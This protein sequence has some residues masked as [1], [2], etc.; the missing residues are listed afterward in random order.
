MKGMEKMPQLTSLVP[1]FL[2]D[3]PGDG[4][5]VSSTQPENRR[6]TAHL[7][8]LRGIASFIVYILHFC[9]PFDRTSVLGFGPGLSYAVYN[10]PILRVFRSGKAMLSTITKDPESTIDVWEEL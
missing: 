4:D 9:M 6:N 7:D 1:T 5:E 10:L 2:R 3:S 8:G